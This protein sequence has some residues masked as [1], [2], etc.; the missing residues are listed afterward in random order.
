LAVGGGGGIA[1]NRT[2]RICG[3]IDP[4]ARF[5]PEK[6]SQPLQHTP[7]PEALVATL[8]AVLDM[9]VLAAASTVSGTA[10]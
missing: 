5:Q 4:R 2:A 8:A 1:A 10:E 9:P 6:L 7:V 3:R